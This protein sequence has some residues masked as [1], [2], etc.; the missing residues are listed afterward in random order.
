MPK[1][2][3][4]KTKR[5]AICVTSI[6][7]SRRVAGPSPRKNC[8]AVKEAQMSTK[9]TARRGESKTAIETADAMADATIVKLMVFARRV[10]IA[11]AVFSFGSA[12]V[13]AAIIAANNPN[14]PPASAIAEL[15]V[16]T[17]IFIV[18]VCLVTLHNV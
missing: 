8:K 14:A 15:I 16:S 10:A 5:M 11:S 18:A 1:Y 13:A 4:M 17:A 7:V 3:K 9:N 6:N 2:K 12:T